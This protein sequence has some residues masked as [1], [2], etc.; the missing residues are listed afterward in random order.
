MYGMKKDTIDRRN[1]KSYYDQNQDKYDCS[2]VYNGK[3][4]QDIGREAPGCHSEEPLA[5]PEA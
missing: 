2:H 1:K 3:S 4:P 5:L